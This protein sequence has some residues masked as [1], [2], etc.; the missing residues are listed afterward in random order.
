MKTHSEIANLLGDAIHL[1]DEFVGFIRA[2][3]KLDEVWTDTKPTNWQHNRLKFQ[4]GGKVLTSAFVRDGYFKALIIFGKREREIFE[5]RQGEFPD[6]VRKIY[7]ATK[8][9]YDGKWLFF[10]VRSHDNALVG[11]LTRMLLIKQKQKK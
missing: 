6:T 9:N 8:V 7:D 4:R 10:E 1:W 2:N 11:E 3:Y 5:A